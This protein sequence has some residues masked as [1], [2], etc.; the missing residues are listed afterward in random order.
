MKN[1]LVTGAGGFVG[2][3]LVR[4]LLDE[5][6]AVTAWVAEASDTWRLADIAGALP[7]E[8]VRFAD[9]EELTGRLR[10][11]KPDWIFHLAAHGAYSFQKDQTRI[12]ETNLLGT[13]QLLGAARTVGTEIFIH[14]GS[15]SEYGV[16]RH[17]TAETEALEPASFYA[18]TKSCATLYGVYAALSLGVPSITLR[19][20]SVYG[21]FEDPRRF[22]PVLL[23]NSLKGCLP[24]LARP[25]VAHDFI[26]VE[27]VCD[28][29]L[30]A[31]AHSKHAR[32]AIYNVGTGVQSSLR[33]IVNLARTELGVTAEPIWGE[34]PD[35]S[36]DSD[37]WVADPQKLRD[38]CGWF[39]KTSLRDGLLRTR[40]WV[41]ASPERLQR[42]T[43]GIASKF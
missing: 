42:Y 41:S 34:H 16:K 38:V 19:L 22:I 14:A 6:H 23:V 7:I 4:R 10:A 33:D 17:P 8:T 18:W 31:A 1:C 39:A 30:E 32:G 26:F 43:G 24:P 36:G 20:Y 29:F 13:V 35:R 11:I 21:P 25:E 28:A 40:D 5:G 12:Y 27:D 37:V 15:S 2:A 9:P 3:N